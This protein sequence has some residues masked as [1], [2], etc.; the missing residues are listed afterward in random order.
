[1]H[2]PDEAPNRRVLKRFLLKLGVPRTEIVVLKNGNE[3]LA[4]L[5][6]ET[7]WATRTSE[8]NDHPS[9]S[10]VVVLMDILMPGMSGIEVMQEVPPLAFSTYAPIAVTGSID[11]ASLALYK[12]VGFV[13]VLP[14]PFGVGELATAIRRTRHL[15]ASN[16][17]A[18]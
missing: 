11:E 1:M 10:R 9:R 17:P 6:D 18:M 13:G 14:K 3:A 16:L 4:Y 12:Q 7:N 15:T 2:V 8:A 5:C